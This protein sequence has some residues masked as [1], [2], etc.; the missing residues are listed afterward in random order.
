MESTFHPI[1][2]FNWPWCLAKAHAS[3]NMTVKSNKHQLLWATRKVWKTPLRGDQWCDLTVVFHGFSYQHLGQ[4]F[5]GWGYSSW[6]LRKQQPWAKAKEAQG[7]FKSTHY[8]WFPGFREYLVDWRPPINGFGKPFDLFLNHVL[9]TPVSRLA[10]S[11]CMTPM[12][13]MNWSLS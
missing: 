3:R 11:R 13:L 1:F 10:G 2:P 6:T 12:N 7:R 5:G 9:Q 4:L 8:D